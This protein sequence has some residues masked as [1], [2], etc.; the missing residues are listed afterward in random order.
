MLN[1][2]FILFNINSTKIKIL[3]YSKKKKSCQTLV[4]K[5]HRV[6]T[7]YSNTIYYMPFWLYNC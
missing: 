1:N 7:V 4:Y 2:R 5:L 3:P 6:K